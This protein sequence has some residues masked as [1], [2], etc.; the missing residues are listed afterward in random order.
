VSRQAL[1]SCT[2]PAIS[3]SLKSWWRLTVTV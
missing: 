2:A 1:A 3:D